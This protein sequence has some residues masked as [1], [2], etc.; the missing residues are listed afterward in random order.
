MSNEDLTVTEPE[1][2]PK[3]LGLQIVAL[4][5]MGR[6]I[7]IQ[8]A[9]GREALDS[10][11]DPGDRVTVYSPLDPDGDPIGALSKSKAGKKAEVVNHAEFLAWARENYPDQ[12]HDAYEVDCAPDA[13]I[14]VLHKHAKHLLKKTVVVD[15]ALI[16]DV[17]KASVKAGVPT[18]PGGEADVPGVKVTKTATKL[19]HL[20]EDGAP[21]AVFELVTS[22]RM[23]LQSLTFPE[24]AGGVA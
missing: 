12:V 6:M 11:L 21:A 18:G 10:I 19:Q 7:G 20:T 3:E 15:P 23:T 5:T 9:A 4:A 8:E 17:R 2:D 14:R 1:L 16:G 22:N 24:I 13:V